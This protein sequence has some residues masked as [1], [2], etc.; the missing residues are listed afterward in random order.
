MIMMPIFQCHYN[1]RGSLCFYDE[2]EHGNVI[3]ECG[4][5]YLISGF[6]RSNALCRLVP[7]VLHRG[8]GAD[9]EQ[10][11]GAVLPGAHLLPPHPA[12]GPRGGGRSG[13]HAKYC[14]AH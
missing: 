10:P 6:Q 14:P 11:A 13:G 12:E 5:R 9:G 2:A 1:Y 7:A 8:G 4:I 3:Y